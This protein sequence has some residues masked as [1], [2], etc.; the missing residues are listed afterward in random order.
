MCEN[1]V[2]A[3]LDEQTRESIL[4][5]AARLTL[6]Q[7]QLLRAEHEP[8]SRV[9]FPIDAVISVVSLMEDGRIAESYTAG[10][11]G[12]AGSEAFW[13]RERTIFRAMCQ[14]PGDCYAI[15]VRALLAIVDGNKRFWDTVNA[16]DHCLLVLAGRSASCGLLH[17]VVERA[18]GGCSSHTIASAKTPSS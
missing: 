6:T 16:Y 18:R 8:I 9:Y 17:N 3:R 1:V 12:M 10:C 15:D 4:E 2:L 13:G 14:V 5:N 11:D 7:W